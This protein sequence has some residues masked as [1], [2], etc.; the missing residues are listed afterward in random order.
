MKETIHY[1]RDPE[2]SELTHLA[3]A[4]QLRGRSILEVGAGAGG[5]TWQVA[6]LTA[7]MTGIDPN[8]T[9]LKKAVLPSPA[10][11][12]LVG[13]IQA[14]GQALPFSTQAFDLVLFASSL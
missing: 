12:P 3:D 2:R 13:F 7:R 1:L 14:N 9:D 4:C 11:Q 5:L 6:P 8:R 10:R